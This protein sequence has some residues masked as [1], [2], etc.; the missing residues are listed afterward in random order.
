MEVLKSGRPA[1][2]VPFAAGSETE[3]S[4]RA[5]LLAARGLLTV[6]NEAELTGASL[7]RGLRQALAQ[8]ERR[9]PRPINMAGAGKTAVLLQD[10]LVRMAP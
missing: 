4:R 7:D 1:L 6:V 5:G 10:M 3:Q 9:P 8:T 2:V